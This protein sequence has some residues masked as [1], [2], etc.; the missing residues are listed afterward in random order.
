MGDALNIVDYSLSNVE[1]R[2]IQSDLLLSSRSLLIRPHTLFFVDQAL[3]DT[4]A[5]ALRLHSLTLFLPSSS[6]TMEGTCLC[7]AI[8]VKVNDQDLFTRRRGHL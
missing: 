4:Y 6:A 2:A 8:V 5:R 3:I 7:G 1:I